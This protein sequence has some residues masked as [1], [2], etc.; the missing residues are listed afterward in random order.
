M[1]VVLTMADDPAFARQAIAAG[2]IGHVLKDA[3]DGELVDAVRDAAHGRS[4]LNPRLGAR[5]VAA[6][7]ATEAEGELALGSTFAGHRIESLAG[8][9]GMG[10]V[11]RATDLAL[12]RQVALKLI[13]PSHVR[14]P[15][16]RARF[17]RECR[18]AAAIDHPHVVPVLHAGE[19]DGRLYLTM[20]YV[21]GTD[22]ARFCVTR[23]DSRR[24]AP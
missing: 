23:A 13:A 5:L 15:V 7:A 10:V 20:R 9:G 4:Y 1:V 19:Q 24:R 18:L 6:A 17:E 16:F 11:Y 3:A 8:R 21:D 2:A 14:D 12:D 22:L